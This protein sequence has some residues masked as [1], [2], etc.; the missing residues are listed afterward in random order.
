MNTIKFSKILLLTTSLLFACT[1]LANG[2]FIDDGKGGANP[3]MTEIGSWQIHHIAFPSTFIQA[4][5]AKAIGLDR[6]GNYGLLNISILD[7]ANNKA[8]LKLKV[9]GYAQ[10]LVGHRKDLEFKEV[11][12]GN[13]VYYLAQVRH[14]NEETFRFYITIKDPKTGHSEQFRFQQKMWVD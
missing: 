6:R 1:A 10:N 11:D 5:T 13:A 9:T 12:E 14:A 4:E 3:N 7:L 8:P 2:E